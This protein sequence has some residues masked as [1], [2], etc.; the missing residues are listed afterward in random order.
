MSVPLQCVPCFWNQMA[1]QSKWIKVESLFK[2]DLNKVNW[3]EYSTKPRVPLRCNCD[4]LCFLGR[5]SVPIG[6]TGDLESKNMW[7]AAQS[8][9]S[10]VHS[11]TT[12]RLR[13]CSKASW[14]KQSSCWQFL[15][16]MWYCPFPR[17][18]PVHCHSQ[19]SQLAVM[20]N[21]FNFVLCWPCSPRH[22][23][24]RAKQ[25]GD[26]NPSREYF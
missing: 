21:C 3:Q 25:L 1:R 10:G 14:G 26:N 6:Y 20:E 23:A 19:S 17:K 2:N 18:M 9:C 8:Q 5:G 7:D 4:C 22:G 16:A 13:S 24:Q 15:L 12:G 11:N